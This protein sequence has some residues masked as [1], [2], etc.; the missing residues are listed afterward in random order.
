MVKKA[1]FVRNLSLDIPPQKYP[2]GIKAINPLPKCVPKR[3]PPCAK[4]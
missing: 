1:K 4:A 2:I 3:I